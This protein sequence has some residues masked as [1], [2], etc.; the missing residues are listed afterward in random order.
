MIKSWAL[1][2]LAGGTMVAADSAWNATLTPQN[3]A[4]VEGTVELKGTGGPDTTM[5]MS[6]QLRNV[7]AGITY[8]TVVH[9]GT[10]AA[11]GGIVGD[12]AAYPRVLADSTA[13]IRGESRIYARPFTEG[14]R[15]AQVHAQPERQ[16]T[17]T[18]PLGPVVACGD[19][20]PV[21]P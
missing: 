7:T 2:L 10:C 12:G 20:K 14:E 13:I 6:V 11:P 3:N 17:N 1:A 8:T 4:T 21:K 15:S 9:N 18:T 5:M 16:I 19:L